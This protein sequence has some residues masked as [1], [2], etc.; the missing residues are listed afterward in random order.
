MKKL[1]K[2][3]AAVI[4]NPDPIFN[5]SEGVKFCFRIDEGSDRGLDF[6]VFITELRRINTHRLQLICS[7]HAPREEMARAQPSSPRIGWGDVSGNE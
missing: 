2:M 3:N 1:A 7:P 6:F 4:P 5:N